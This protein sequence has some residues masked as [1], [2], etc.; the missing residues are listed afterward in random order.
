M[1]RYFKLIILIFLFSCHRSATD[2][3]DHQTSP[4]LA[5][6]AREEL[7]AIAPTELH[8]AVLNRD[9]EA[10]KSAAQNGYA[11]NVINDKFG[12]TPLQLAME[13]KE[14]AIS[15]YLSFFPNLDI[16]HKN[17]KAEG[18][19]FT[20]SKNGMFRV[21][22]ILYDRHKQ[23]N[24]LL[25]GL[26]Y[27]NI[28]FK[29][30]LGQRALHVALNPET[31]E[32]MRL[33]GY[34]SAGRIF[35]QDLE[36]R[37]PIHQAAIDQ[38]NTFFHWA[39][40]RYCQDYHEYFRHSVLPDWA[41]KWLASGL[42]SSV[43]IVRWLS[44][45][46]RWEWYNLIA[47]NPFNYPDADGNTSLHLAVQTGSWSV[48]Q[49]TLGCEFSNLSQTNQ[50]NKNVLHIAAQVRDSRVIELLLSG[51]LIHTWWTQRAEWL[52]HLDQKGYTP[53]HYA[54]LNAY[55]GRSY[56]L[57]L[58][59]GANE[60]VLSPKGESAVELFKATQQIREQNKLAGEM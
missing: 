35:D 13:L 4:W 47:A 1:D 11:V 22:Q 12:E 34:W 46:A 54:A 36:G 50:Q 31:A 15:E 41:N 29:N 58:K 57:L 43:E 28:D 17:L 56:E 26:E 7:Q 55:Q 10:V 23:F 33:S 2:E 9:L 30:H 38:R 18:Y 24:N 14:Y 3:A 20:A 21:I 49:A 27:K 32:A 5:K 48:V 60:Q 44:P 53:L 25:R 19:L 6:Y 45:K 8:K 40:Q 42:K 51:R 16:Y 59:A 37:T 52:N 39:A